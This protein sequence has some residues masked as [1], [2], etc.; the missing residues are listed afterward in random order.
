MALGAPGLTTRSV[1]TEGTE[2]LSGLR[3]EP[4]AFPRLR[5][6]PVAVHRV[7]PR[8]ADR[9]GVFGDHVR[10]GD[11]DHDAVLHPELDDVEER[12][13]PRRAAPEILGPPALAFAETLDCRTIDR[14]RQEQMEWHVAWRRLPGAALLVVAAAGHQG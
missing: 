1:H 12:L 10:G 5:R 11:L 13:L 9:V 3:V 8:E 7:Q 2:V 14:H 6:R 4:F